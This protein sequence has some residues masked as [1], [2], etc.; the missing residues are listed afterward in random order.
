MSGHPANPL[1][2]QVHKATAPTPGFRGATA[3]PSASGSHNNSPTQQDQQTRS[4]RGGSH[5]GTQGCIHRIAHSPDKVSHYDRSTRL[6]AT[7]GPVANITKPRPQ[8]A[9]LRVPL[10]F[11]RTT[12]TPET[13]DR[14]ACPGRPG[15]RGTPKHGDRSA[16][17]NFGC[18]CPDAC[19]DKARKAKLQ[20]VGRYTPART[21]AIGTTRRLQALA[22]LG[23]SPAVIA[24]TFCTGFQLE[25]IR[26][27]KTRGVTRAIAE[28]VRDFY[29]D[30]QDQPLPNIT[31][32]RQVRNT[33]KS[34]KWAHPLRW[35][36]S[37]IDD[38]NAAPLNR[39]R[40]VELDLGGVNE[41]I[42]LQLLLSGHAKDLPSGT[43]EVRQYWRTLTL[44]AVNI[45]TER[46]YSIEET[47]AKL[48]I[49]ERRV[50]RH[51]KIHLDKF[52]RGTEFNG[53]EQ[54]ETTPSD[55]TP[56]EA[57]VA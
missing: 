8:P 9:T 6:D 11:G 2:D 25:T 17:D 54:S 22:C 15:V 56:R 13:I 45:L 27:G 31:S 5:Q 32:T 57:H 36:D 47:A 51:R 23:Y 33:A 49:P 52:G 28:H 7:N 43:V 4:G 30:H 14:S 53:G 24:G 40:A 20:R 38:P 10:R 19:R 55:T 21:P 50:D 34:R 18:R 42:D 26:K 29:G 35:T 44:Q 12:T 1:S 48:K 41:E 3:G 37:T 39:H 16:Y 46:G